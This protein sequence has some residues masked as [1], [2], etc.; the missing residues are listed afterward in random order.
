MSTADD[1]FEHGR[2][3][4]RL[5][6]PEFGDVAGLDVGA[7]LADLRSVLVEANRLEARK[8]AVL[9]Q[10]FAVRDDARRCRVES[11]R[12]FVG[13]WDELVAEVGAVLQVGRSGA[14]AAVHRGLDLRE[15]LPRVFAVCAT[16]IVTNQQLYAVLRYASAIIDD[17]VLHE[18]DVR[19]A[20]WLS[21][22]LSD[23]DTAVTASA[24]EEAA[25]QILVRIDIDA[26][27]QVPEKKPRFGIDMHARADGTVDVEAIIPKADGIRFAALLAEMLKTTC[28]KD[29]RTLGERQVGAHAAL[30]EGYETLGCQCSDDACRFK[31]RRPRV[32]AIAPEMRALA[33]IVLN[34]SDLR[35]TEPA[36]AE[37]QPATTT[38][39]ASTAESAV[40]DVITLFDE[41]PAAEGT[42]DEADDADGADVTNDADGADVTNDEDNADRSDDADLTNVADDVSGTTGG[43]MSGDSGAQPVSSPPDSSGGAYVVCDE[44]GISGPVTAEQANDLIAECDTTIRA[45]GKRDPVTGEIHIA[46]A[47]GYT[48]TQYQLLIMRLTYPTCVFPGCSVP[49]TRSQADHVA[50]YDHRNPARGGRTTV[51]GKHGPGNLVP[52]CGFHHRIK[53]E[54]GWL[55]DLLDDGTVEWHHPAGGI[56]LTPPGAAQEI[57]PGLGKLIWDTPARIESEEP[58]QPETLDTHA[59]LRAQTRRDERT[60]NRRI[61]LEKA[62][63]RAEERLRKEL[64]RQRK[65][66][67]E[68]GVE[69][70]PNTD[71]EPPPF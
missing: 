22:M 15:R 17:R 21:G 54:T 65:Q 10:L 34:E 56:W 18:F 66:A 59:E 30:I 29:P 52:L 48:P 39:E 11:D 26:V 1:G 20:A 71:P 49:S 43:I 63:K 58:P 41:P 19:M 42:A 14:S 35:T 47:S 61:R 4:R 5:L 23:P 8:N 55:S 31:E 40:D 70:V 45:L 36:A 16:G 68:Q 37:P 24:V 62:A 64:E 38:S 33:L 3:V 57:L 7:L 12:R 25:K 69:F 9:S 50:E 53:T 46:G 60:K 28:R 51:A 13:D 6:P 2:V 27:P 67:E 32:A 44:L